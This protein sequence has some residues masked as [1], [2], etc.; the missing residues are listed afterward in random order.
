MLVKQMEEALMGVLMMAGKRAG[1]RI[2][3]SMHKSPSVRTVL[4]AVKGAKQRA[5]SVTKQSARL[6]RVY[7]VLGRQVQI[8]HEACAMRRS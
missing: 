7:G 5:L 3:D 6:D 1:Q 4:F 2:T 8:M